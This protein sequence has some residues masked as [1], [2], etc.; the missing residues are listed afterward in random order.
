K[1]GGAYVPLDPSY[2]AARL[3]F[4][5][6]DSAP[7]ALLVDSAGQTVL[8]GQEIAV[9]VIDLGNAAQWAR[10]PPANLDCTSLGLT[11]HHLAYVIYT[12]GSTGTPKGVM[13]EHASIFNHIEWQC[14]TFG[15]TRNDR[16]LQRT[17]ASFDASVWEI[18]TPLAIGAR[19]IVVA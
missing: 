16:F 15:F 3:A 17:S 5:L 1:A 4:M 7:V 6:K 9:S 13:V 12:S 10:K 19:L 8:A 11:P 18:W 2:P 14:S